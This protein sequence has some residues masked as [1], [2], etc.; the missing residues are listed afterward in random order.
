MKANVTPPRSRPYPPALLLALLTLA[1]LVFLAASPLSALP[2]LS[3]TTRHSQ[4][5]TR[6]SSVLA[7]VPLPCSLTVAETE[8]PYYR[9]G[10]PERTSLLETG[11]V[12][13]RV[14]VN[15]YV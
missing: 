2:A 15:G 9:A 3:G 6:N 7:L 13:A 14:L 11:M 5:A 12:G 1:A 4:L 8:G 10:S